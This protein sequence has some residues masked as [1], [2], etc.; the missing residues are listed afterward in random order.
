M[1][2]QL[3]YITNIK[4]KRTVVGISF[5][6]APE[7][8]FSA[9][10][11]LPNQNAFMSF[12]NTQEQ[13]IGVSIGRYSL[14]TIY[15]YMNNYFQEDWEGEIE[16]GTAQIQFSNGDTLVTDMGKIAIY[17]DGDNS[18]GDNKIVDNIIANNITASNYLGNDSALSGDYSSS[19]NNGVSFTGYTVNQD[20]KLME[21]NSPILV[22][23]LDMLELNVK[24]V[25][26]NEIAGMEVMEGGSLV[27]K[28][29]FT[30]LQ[31]RNSNYDIYDI[32]P[33]LYYKLP[34][35]TIGSIR[36]GN[37]HEKRYFDGMK[38]ILSYLWKR[39]AF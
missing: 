4:D 18:D 23:A 38:D 1:P 26:Y 30:S 34:D 12:R 39:G 7:F 33:K 24:G 11:Y 29:T 22:A 9:T 17:S 15:L 25:N 5:D 28:S 21:I 3:Q 16:L 10:E 20:I 32:R 19:S 37:I 14:R 2:I 36:H 6:E 8:N 27:I 35:G 13:A 31:G